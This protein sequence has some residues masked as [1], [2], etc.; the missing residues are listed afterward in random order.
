MKFAPELSSTSG[1]WLCLVPPEVMMR[2][3]WSQG[4]PN[5][6]DGELVSRLAPDSLAIRPYN[7]WGLRGGWYVRVSSSYS[8]VPK[9]M[10]PGWVEWGCRTADWRPPLSTWLC[11]SWQLSCNKH[12][13][14]SCVH[15]HLNLLAWNRF[16]MEFENKILKKKMVSYG[17][18]HD[19]S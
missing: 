3:G 15:D 9:P 19:F 17:I 7:T 6:V 5:P 2:G 12:R 18:V 14:R 11:G 10:Q 16:S 1:R 4:I 8:R 13:P